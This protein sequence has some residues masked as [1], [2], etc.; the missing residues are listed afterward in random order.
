M[1]R[2]RFT[3]DN[4]DAKVK[5]MAQSVADYWTERTGCRHVV[6]YRDHYDDTR[7]RGDYV[8]RAA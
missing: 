5:A 7:V 2:E 6:E 4:F 1:E 3:A 8:V